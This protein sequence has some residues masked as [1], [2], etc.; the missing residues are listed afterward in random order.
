MAVRTVFRNRAPK[1]EGFWEGLGLRSAEKRLNRLARRREPDIRRMAVFSHDLMGTQI[2]LYG[3]G[4]RD[5]IEDLFLFL[6]PLA[7]RMAAGVALDVGANVGNHAVAFAERFGRVLAFEPNPAVH[8]L[9]VINTRALGNVETFPLGLGEAALAARLEEGVG[10]FGESRVLGAGEAPGAGAVVE[11]RIARMDEVL[12]GI[13]GDIVLVKIDVEGHEEQV[14][15][16]GI[17]TLRRHAP[18]VVFEQH[19]GEFAGGTTPSIEIL[20]GLGYTICWSEYPRERLRSS[21]LRD[22]A[23]VRDRLT[24][25]R[26]EIV[27]GA[28][29]TVKSHSMLIAVPEGLRG[30]LCGEGARPAG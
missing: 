14:L 12:A 13:G 29:V 10:N 22:L 17:E 8:E 4:E 27:T 23:K 28:A 19:R 2:N 6:A 7:D 16:G 24:R 21:L 15:K 11:V 30:L 9:L 18:V 25:R 5:E 26:P 20:R 1:P 3:R